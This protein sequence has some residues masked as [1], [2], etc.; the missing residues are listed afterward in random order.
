[1]GR[2]LDT[3][4]FIIKPAYNKLAPCSIIH[5]SHSQYHTIYRTIPFTITIINHHT[6]NETPLLT[7]QHIDN[8]EQIDRI[9]ESAWAIFHNPETL[10]LNTQEM[11]AVFI[12]LADASWD[13][14][15]YLLFELFK[16]MGTDEMLHEDI[17][18]SGCLLYHPHPFLLSAIL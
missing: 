18:V 11:L 2:K 4:C 10:T 5:I 13:R 14:R 16:M 15:L 6:Y 9:A 7:H 1:M 8:N 17:Q 12:L 3:E